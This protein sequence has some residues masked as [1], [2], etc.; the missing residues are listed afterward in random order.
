MAALVNPVFL[1]RLA[2]LLPLSAPDTVSNIF[3]EPG[4]C[5]QPGSYRCLQTQDT[6]SHSGYSLLEQAGKLFASVYLKYCF[7]DLYRPRDVHAY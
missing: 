3:S 2:I 6:D 1:K 7:Q 4:I 5:M